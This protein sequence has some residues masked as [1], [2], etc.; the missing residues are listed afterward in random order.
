MKRIYTY[1]GYP[2][3][4]NLTVAD[5]KAG[6]GKRK[7]VQTT[8]V[9]RIEAAAAEATGI[10]HLSIVDHDLVE[11]RAGAPNTFTTA[12]LMASD[13]ET[14]KDI[15]R[16]GIRAA[17]A[18]ADAVYTLRSFKAVE[19]LADEGLAVQGHLGLVPRLSTQIGGLRAYGR[20]AD[21]AMQLADDLRRLEEAGAYAVELECVA[22]EAIAEISP[23][24][25]L[26]THS[27]GSGGAAD[28][29]FLFQDDACGDTVDPPRH[30]KA[31]ADMA[32]ARVQLEAERMKGLTAY[33]AA[34]L[35]G[36][37]PYAATSIS[38]KPGEQDKLREALDKRRPFHE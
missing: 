7:F 35:N 27:I 32:S 36:S 22:D 20:T 29:I 6:K 17:A 16:A 21:E 5:I 14:Q 38:M 25:G 30:A 1:G 33:R 26:I 13:Y 4:R 11:V 24:T 3:T 9:N 23:R 37:Y 8:A 12:A 2:A 34:V 10:D 19:L 28:V 18:G 31:F 15:L